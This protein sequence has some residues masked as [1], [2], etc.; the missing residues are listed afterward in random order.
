MSVNLLKKGYLLEEDLV[1]A[2]GVPS[3]E[4][5][6]KG[7]VAVIEC[8]QN[9]PCDPCRDACLK[10]AVTMGDEIT[11]TPVLDAENCHGCAICVA[12]CPGQAIFVVDET[13][14]D[15]KA[16]VTVPYEFYP[17]P[18]E[19]EIVTALDRSGAPLGD[20]EIVKVRM[21]PKQDATAL[22]S[23][24]VPLDWSMKARFFKGKESA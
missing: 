4:E 1:G 11:N 17:L 7:P 14:A 12:R 16:L 3:A 5:R 9:I 22:V 2:S 10:G 19:G 8:V 23:L 15:G 24:A 13:Y 18:K 6:A 21:K 20:A